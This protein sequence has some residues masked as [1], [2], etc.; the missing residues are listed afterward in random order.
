MRAEALAAFEAKLRPLLTR[1]PPW[2]AIRVYSQGR[3]FFLRSFS[4]SVPADPIEVPGA[5]RTLWGLRFR[6]SLFNAAGM[7][8]YGEGYELAAMQGAGAYLA[9]TTTHLPRVGNRKGG[10]MQPFAPYPRSGAASNWLGLPNPGHRAVAERLRQVERREGCPVGA[11]AAACP[12]PRVADEDKLEQLVAG[13]NLYEDTG[14]DFLEMNES[15][16]NTEQGESDLRGRLAYVSEHFLGRRRRPFPVIVK[17]S[18]DTSP[19]QV[20]MLVSMLV[21]LGFDGV[22][23]GNTSIQ[24][25]LHRPRIAPAETSLYDFFTGTYGG[26]V[27]GHPLKET[28][29]QL[30]QLAVDRVSELSPDREF[31]VIRTGGIE[32]A[33]DVERSEQAGVVLNQW[34]SGY[35]EAFSHAGHELYRR[36]FSQSLPASARGTTATRAN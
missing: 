21:D 26:G 28:S 7:F 25:G 13:M 19:D 35:F 16:P 14:I 6:S 22:N 15:C 36:F 18:C 1:L 29:L 9:G 12:N 5:E 8:K 4:R 2:L 31:Y 3:R 24:Y 17:L 11:S 32:S 20:A 27:S 30:A 23:F 34:Y 33:E 10:V